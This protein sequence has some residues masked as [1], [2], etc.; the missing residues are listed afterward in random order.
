M[1]GKSQRRHE[2][3]I[4]APAE[5]TISGQVTDFSPRFVVGLTTPQIAIP[6]PPVALLRGV[7][8]APHARCAGRRWSLKMI[9][10]HDH[11]RVFI[12]AIKAPSAP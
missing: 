9:P 4:P 11:T 6:S 3:G 2:L 8:A 12:A 1:V 5:V 7:I 10:I